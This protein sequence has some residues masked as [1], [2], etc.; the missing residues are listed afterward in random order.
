MSRFNF[1]KYKRF[2][3]VALAVLFLFSVA[4]FTTKVFSNEQ[5]KIKIEFNGDT[6]EVKTGDAFNKNWTSKEQTLTFNVN[7][8]EYFSKLPENTTP[9][10]PVADIPFQV[11]NAQFGDNKIE[12]QA[13]KIVP[14]EPNFNGVYKVE[15]TLPENPKEDEQLK[16]TL[17]T[18][19]D[20]KFGISENEEVSFHI[21]R[22]TTAP[23]VSIDGIEENVLYKDTPRM[24]VEVKEKNFDEKLVS[25]DI[26]KDEGTY[27][28]DV[29]F[30]NQGDD[31]YTFEHSFDKQGEY[32]VVVKA[33]DEAGNIAEK[34]VAFAYDKDGPSLQVEG[35]PNNGFS[36]KSDNT[37]IIKSNRKIREVK[38]YAI[39]KDNKP[40][41]IDKQFVINKKE[42]TLNHTFEDGTYKVNAI[43]LVNKFFG[44][45]EKQ[46]AYTFTVDTVKPTASLGGIS[47]TISNKKQVVTVQLGDKHL[48]KNNT[49]FEIKK[50]NQS[51]LHLTADQL[52][53][54]KNN[55]PFEDE[56]N[57]EVSLKAVDKAQNETNSKVAFII[58]KT[59]P[60]LEI[61]NVIDNA[62]YNDK[63][64][65]VVVKVVD[66]TLEKAT[67]TIV[68]N[69]VEETR[70]VAVNGSEASE[71]LTFTEEGIYTIKLNGEDKATNI[72]NKEVSFTIDKTAPTFTYSGIENNG[73]YTEEKELTINVSEQYLHEDSK[74][75]ILRN[76]KV[77]QEMNVQTGANKYAFKKDG[78]YEVLIT[79]KD[80]AG[81]TVESKLT[82]IID[83]KGTEITIDAGELKEPYHYQ[84][85]EVTIT[86]EDL[87]LD[88]DKTTVSVT[89]D[90]EPYKMPELK[91]QD[92]NELGERVAQLTHTFKE[93]GDYVI[94]VV[95]LDGLGHQSSKSI[96][97]TID[98]N[99]PVLTL[100][101]I[102]EGSFIKADN[103]L[104]VTVN[105]HNFLHNKV[106]LSVIKDGKAYD[107]FTW[108]NVEDNKATISSKKH[109]FKE[110][111]DY[112]VSFE[113]VDAAGN[114]AEQ[115]TLSFTV[116]TI[117]PTIH[118]NGVENN[119]YYNG[120]RD[121]VIRVNEHNYDNNKVTVDVTKN[122]QAFDIGEWNNTGE[123]SEL[124]YTF[125]EDAVY[126]IKVTATDKAGNDTVT[127]EKTFTIDKTLPDLSITGV[128]NMAHYNVDKNVK[129]RVTDTNIDEGKTS[130]TVTKDGKFYPTEKLHVS[131]TNA[132]L[133]VVFKEAG[134]YVLNLKATDKAQNTVTH[135]TIRFT[136][137][138][139]TPVLKIEGVENNSFNDKN[140]LVTLSID[141][142][143]YE[144][145]N[146]EL[147]VTKDKE[148]YSIGEWK[149]SSK[150]SKLSYLFDQDGLYTIALK[151]TD[152]AGN[153]PVTAKITFTIDKTKPT[154]TITGVE[155]DNYY[156]VSKQMNVQI[157]DNNLAQNKIRVT[158]DGRS[159]SVGSF[160]INGLIASLSHH[161]VQEG[162]YDIL[163]EAI[164]KAGNTFSMPMVFT[165]DKTAPVIT[166]KMKGGDKI[167][168]G[169]FINKIFTPEFALDKQEDSIVTVTLNGGG[170]IA[171]RIPVA[172]KEMEYKYHVVAMD[173]AKNETKLDVAFT[174]DTTLPELKITGIMDGYFSKNIAPVVTYS[175]KH[176]DKGKSS[177]L[178]NNESYKNGTVLKKEQDYVLN[179][180]INDLA[181][182]L[183][184]RS[185]VF[186]ID[187]TKPVI[188]FKDPINLKYFNEDI[189]PEFFIK[190]FSEYDI[191]SLTLDGVDYIKGTPITEEGKHVLYVEV[192]DKAGNIKQISVEFVLDKTAPV[193]IYE[194]VQKNKKYYNSVDLA[195]RLHNPQDQI[196]SVTINDELFEGN[197]IEKDGVSILKTTVRNIA[198]YEVKVKAADVAGNEVTD[199]LNFEIAEKNAI[200]K[201]YENKLLFIGSIVGL[202]ALL[203][204]GAFFIMRKPEILDEE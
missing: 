189:L 152:K 147:V 181:K 164:D 118:I 108:N 157:S 79:L 66:D 63:E 133:Q 5:S 193:V 90:K 145:N 45:E 122:G 88:K 114:K 3:Y 197:M 95:S 87:T 46:I 19:A 24:I 17:K 104:I 94:N 160:S 48:D 98:N 31:V 155:K 194:G 199:T 143:N 128:E 191:I 11:E 177:V 85:K 72:A 57:Y 59:A 58:D 71:K 161:F 106:T 146:V 158:Q 9:I 112:V 150:L 102:K 180:A 56:G 29:S 165:V 179:A 171:G 204:V 13:L 139:T 4:F 132:T 105:E 192:K 178:L 154:I 78:I 15:A 41:P 33:T 170:N 188:T 162:K 30:A 144:T 111:G 47:S 120:N 195:I 6:W 89:K 126:H 196:K 151:A 119:A 92:K 1:S 34:K 28:L 96:S 123:T 100:E 183:S 32:A 186:T 75:A 131:G 49:I 156:N 107:A 55:Y 142:L 73:K 20:N 39:T 127:E 91:E 167:T 93:D 138:K 40:Y 202:I 10:D 70:N 169:A 7:L 110:D 22:D 23:V 166:P 136:I 50:N 116:D 99:A 67:V 14:V 201:V 38:S 83:K 182:N 82:F 18:I 113:A 168:N 125:E 27:P 21:T 203:G 25:I 68:K 184:A 61:S 175:D 86:V 54:I 35:I 149:N 12:G 163:V 185:I 172:S 159:Y 53:D 134:N 52:D 8:T 77:Q 26:V 44:E 60:T 124:A 2:S 101:G 135:D 153:G 115:E 190:D 62:H 140:K 103:Q 174:V 74:V 64:K 117:S 51:I 80:K 173:R 69:K 176:L 76:G 81:N 129:V 130:F 16:V 200:V 42:A 148:T 65:E 198:K 97:F 137:D 187:K 43:I 121:V 109:T 141:E 36:A 84:E 37:L